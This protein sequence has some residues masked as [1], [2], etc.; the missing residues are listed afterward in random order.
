MGVFRQ[1]YCNS[2]ANSTGFKDVS[3]GE[4]VRSLKHEDSVT[5]G[6]VQASVSQKSKSNSLQFEDNSMKTVIA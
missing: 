5:E 6:S 2:I 1:N 4:V 3:S